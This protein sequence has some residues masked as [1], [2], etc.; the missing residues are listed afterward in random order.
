MYYI[1]NANGS[2]VSVCNSK[3][4]IADLATRN[5]MAIESQEHYD[6]KR[7][8]LEANAIVVIN[9]TAEQHREQIKQTLLRAVDNYLD[10]TVQQRG[11]DNI[12]KCVTYEGDI[13]PIFNAEGTAAKQWRSKVYRTC[14][15][16]LAEVEAG[17]RGIPTVE[18][19]I[20]ELPKIEW[21][22]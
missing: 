10:G 17:L 20:A 15:N 8:R 19:L 13:D 21:G 5:E 22:D 2:C 1:F 7:I 3:P 16:I 9:L 11:Y 12:A 18:E 4:N 14:Y 6:I